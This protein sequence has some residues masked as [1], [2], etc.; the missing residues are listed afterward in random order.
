MKRKV[1][2]KYFLAVFA[3]GIAIYLGACKKNAVTP[4]INNTNS[5]TV[6]DPYYTEEARK[7]VGKINNFKTKLV[8]KEYLTKGDEYISID[9]VIWN[10]EALF[11][12]SYTFPERKYEETVKQ[13]LEFLVEANAN[14]EVLMS[15]V[16]DLYDL[17]IN[18]VR[19]AY[20]N[21]GIAF[22][23]SLMAVDI[24][25]GE[26]SGNNFSII[27]HVISGRVDNSLSVKDPVSGPFGP[28]DCWYFGEYGGTCDDPS[29]FGDAAE[30]IED[31]INYY[32]RGT[33][34]P[35]SGYRGLNHNL[36][37]VF[38]DGNEY[39]DENGNYYTYFYGLND[40]PPFYLG[41]DMLNYYFNREL[42]LILNVVP[43]DP[44]FQGLWPSCPAFL[45]VDIVGLIGNVGT[46]S[47][48]YHRNAITYCSRLLIPSQAMPMPVD[49][50]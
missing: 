4:I 29:A 17:I 27:A 33:G 12:A 16:A 44:V 9:S 49:L 35:N 43:S 41:Y 8:D 5:T 21:D 36:V 40:D 11:N 6:D 28:G 38:L 1:C 50:L 2:L 48:A 24:E 37:R 30:V 26:K 47:Y 45:E 10:V 14:G 22:D 23:K 31:S 20:A 19:Q 46:Q 15:A 3:V 7:I 25:K 39:V 42:A 13:E 18:D 34:V 32:Y